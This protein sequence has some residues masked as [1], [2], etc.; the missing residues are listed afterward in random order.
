MARGKLYCGLVSVLFLLLSACSSAPELLDKKA[1]YRLIPADDSP[2][3][4]YVSPL[5][6]EHPDK[7]GVIPLIN[8]LDA[9]IAGCG[10]PISF[11]IDPVVAGVIGQAKDFEHRITEERGQSPAGGSELKRQFCLLN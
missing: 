8:G 3:A 10:F 5:I 9:F 11:S 7:T 1:S 4:T 6:E 2:L